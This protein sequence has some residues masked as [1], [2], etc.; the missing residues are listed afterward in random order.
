MEKMY[1]EFREIYK[2][3][4]G[5]ELSDIE[6]MKKAD[7]FMD[8]MRLIVKKVHDRSESLGDDIVKENG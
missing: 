6:T 4:T 1:E 7:Q 3:E 2:V 5:V 8:L